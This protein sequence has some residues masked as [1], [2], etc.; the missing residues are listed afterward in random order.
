MDAIYTFDYAVLEFIHD[1]FVCPVL[2]YIMSF[3]T[4]LAEDGI[5]CI[6]LGVLLICFK[7]TRR[8]GITLGFALLFGAL[9]TNITLKPLICRVR[10]Y[11]NELYE[12]SVGIADLSPLIEINTD[13]SFPSGHTTCIFETATAIFAYR[14]KWGSAAYGVAVLTA[15]SRLY[16]YQHY[17][18][19]VLAGMAIGIAAGIGAYWFVKWAEPLYYKIGFDKLFELLWDGP[20]RKLGEKMAKKKN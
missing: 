13:F 9:T 2:D 11:L 19:D 15:F 14:K 17:F 3:F 10:P 16:F 18:T 1:T 4:L 7:K 12:H 20:W 8:I 5:I 6:A